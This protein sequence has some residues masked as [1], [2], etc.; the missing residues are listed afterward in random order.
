MECHLVTEDQHVHNRDVISHFFQ[1][2]ATENHTASLCP[3]VS[4]V[5]ESVI[6]MDR[7]YCSEECSSA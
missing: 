3:C 1:E 4:A 5:A 6:D 7:F 2:A